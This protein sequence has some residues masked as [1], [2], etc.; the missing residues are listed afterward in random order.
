M[1]VTDWEPNPNNTLAKAKDRLRPNVVITD[2]VS[3]FSDP[4]FWGPLNVI[5]PE[6][7][8]ESAINKIRRQLRRN[9]D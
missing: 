3:G 4:D 8:I 1:A 9:G 2:Q 7:S 5:E 6:K